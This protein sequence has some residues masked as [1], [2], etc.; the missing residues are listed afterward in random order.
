MKL[1]LTLALAALLGQGCVTGPDEVAAEKNK[2]NSQ[3]SIPVVKDESAEMTADA[4]DA[5]VPAGG[6]SEAAAAEFQRTGTGLGY[7]IIRQGTG[8]R[9]TGRSTV[10]CHYKGWLDDGT[11]FDSSLGGDPISFPLDG[12]IAGWT[13]G[14]QLIKEGGKIELD[15]P[16]KLG[17]GARGAP[18]AIPP[19]ARLHFEIELIKV[20]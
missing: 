5:V 17:Y 8:K 11:V 2:L 13:E 3:E 14:L 7:K 18:G 15:I 4:S 9:P 10:T 12:V 19:N 20:R 16:S 6:E 1:K